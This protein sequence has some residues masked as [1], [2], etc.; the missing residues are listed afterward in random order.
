MCGNVLIHSFIIQMLLMTYYVQGPVLSTTWE[1]TRET[2]S[3]AY[4]ST[5]LY[6]RQSTREH[7]S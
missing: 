5:V 4:E 2:S 7:M 3:L 6:M 1:Q